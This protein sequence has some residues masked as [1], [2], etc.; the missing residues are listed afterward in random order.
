MK[1][2]L[3]GKRGNAEKMAADLGLSEITAQ[4]LLNRGIYSAKGV[5]EFFN[6]R[7]EAF[8]DISS[9][10]EVEKGFEIVKESIR[11][12]EKIT[13]YGDYDAD[14][15]MSSTILIKGLRGLGARAECYIPHRLYEGYGL[16]MGAVKKIAD[17]GTGLIIC[18]DNGIAAIEECGYIKALGMKLV[19]LDHHS[20]YTD[21]SGNEILPKADALIDLKLKDCNYSFKELCAGGLCYRFISGLYASI[22]RKID[23]EAELFIFASIATI[24][25]MVELQGENRVFAHL[26][27]RLMNSRKNTNLGLREV[28]S[29]LSLAGKE[30]DDRS[31][32]FGIGP[33][34]NS[35]GRMGKAADYIDIFLSDDRERVTELV[36]ELKVLNE[37]RKLLTD[38]AYVKAAERLKDNNED[39]VIVEYLPYIH[40][41]LAGLAAGKLKERFSRPVIVLS[42]GESCV[43][44]SGRSVEGYNMFSAVNGCRDLLLR[45]GGHSQ[46]VGLSLEE[47]NI[48]EL[49]R[50]LNEGCCLSLEDM[51][52]KIY[53][54]RET[55]FNEIS[56]ELSRELKALKPFGTGNPTPV[57]A[58]KGVFVKRLRFVGKQRRV[59][60]FVFYHNETELKGVGFGIF[61]KLKD[62]I[63]SRCG[64]NVWDELYNGQGVV[65]FFADILFG[66][67]EN[68]FNG[69]SSVQL[70][71]ED[72]RAFEEG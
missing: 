14:G 6:P 51:E 4:V 65:Q 48:A 22:G 3:R 34:I 53:I 32:G 66:I 25:D 56:L 43:K 5:R 41:S 33:F 18:C 47:E 13:V 62:F 28:I 8:G 2:I 31:V 40:E 67:E 20:P 29:A 11:K 68:F 17:G 70:V 50:R 39:K 57:F 27:L 44:G 37:Q 35:A 60:Q 59:V 23:K 45:F 63:I 46:A 61:D 72:F 69:R 52:R 16:N 19:V 1:W 10:P 9:L 55:G 49:K 26:G 64:E 38:E 7:I 54:D 21:K 30:I 15:V 42:K 71:L 12:G 58:A 24:C 36:E